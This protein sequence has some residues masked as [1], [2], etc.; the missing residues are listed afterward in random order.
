METLPERF[1]EPFVLTQDVNCNVARLLVRGGREEAAAF[2]AR[3]GVQV[4]VR[5]LSLERIFP[6]LRAEE[7]P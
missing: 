6:L 2:Q 3:Y 5:P 1:P 7:R 4:V